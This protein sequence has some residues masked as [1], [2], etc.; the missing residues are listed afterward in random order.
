MNSTLNTSC[1]IV[2][3]GAGIIGLSIA[4]AA[5]ERDRKLKII[6]LDKE[7]SIGL[8][9]SGRNSGVL[10]TGVYYPS[11][12]MKAKFC[13][14]GAKMLREFC[15][16][17]K[18]PINVCGK[19]ILPINESDDK[20]LDMLVERA[21]KNGAKAHIIDS[22]ALKAIE[23]KAKTVTGRAIHCPES[24]VVDSGAILAQ[25]KA[26]LEAQGVRFLLGKQVISGSKSNAFIQTQ[27]GVQI[28]F[29]HLINAA[30]LHADKVAKIFDVGHRYRIVPFKGTYFELSTPDTA[31]YRGHIYPVP[32]LTLPFL[33][34][35]FTK[36]VTGKIYL[37]PNALPAL[38]R[39]NYQG[40]AGIDISD[41][42]NISGLVTR[43]YWNNKQS[44]RKLVH[45]ELLNFNKSKF[46]KAAQAI[47]PSLRKD[48]IKRSAK[49]GI[50]AQLYDIESK[51]L[52]MDFLCEKGLKST[53]ILNAISPAFTS[54]FSFADYLFENK[55]I[56]FD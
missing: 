6:V 36:S 32:N 24:A 8:H 14:D 23:P 34:V 45:T 48:D 33:G 41:L 25:L 13:G 50:R 4:R 27:D 39:E 16:E 53:H 38:G 55:F 21:A 47:V 7:N 9:S 19:V 46:T 31:N 56:N 43:Q 10:H 51:N 5:L 35:H 15:F 30:G 2:I 28:H 40:L 22:I 1:D 42:V 3:V 11:D 29:G 52:V 44:F 26:N 54:S 49:V 12:S 37:G 20:T 18:L 17:Y